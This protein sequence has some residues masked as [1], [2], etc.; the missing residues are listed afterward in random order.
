VGA[1]MSSTSSHRAIFVNQTRN[2]RIFDL[3]PELGFSIL[4][5]KDDHR[6]YDFAR[7]IFTNG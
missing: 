6:R 5:Y 4:V 2:V 7:F 3:L 1:E